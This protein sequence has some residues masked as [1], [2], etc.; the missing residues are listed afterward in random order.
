MRRTSSIYAAMCLLGLPGLSP[1]ATIV[2]DA[3]GGGDFTNIQAALD[4]AAD[5]DRVLVRPGTYS[6][7][8]PL[9]F[10]RLLP[11]FPLPPGTRDLVLESEAGPS[12]T[13]I[14]GTNQGAVILF[15]HAESA[16]SAVIGFTLTGGSYGVAYEGAP[17]G[18]GVGLSAALRD[19]IIEGNQS[20]G[21]VWSDG[22]NPAV[23]EDCVIVDNAGTGAG[24]PEDRPDGLLKRCLIARN[25]RFGVSYTTAVDCEIADNGGAGIVGTE[26]LG[27]RITGNALGVECT[28]TSGSEVTDCLIARNTG[29]GVHGVESSC[30]I[31][32]SAI[33]ENG[34][35]GVSLSG[36]GHLEVT[37]STIV[38]NGGDGIFICDLNNER[39]VVESSI[40]WG[41]AGASILMPIDCHE[42]D[43]LGQ[44]PIVRYC[45]TSEPIP[46]E[47]NISADPLFCEGP[48][49]D[50]LAL[51][52]GS[53]CIGTGFDGA[54]MGASA[55]T[56][57][58]SIVDDGGPGTQAEGNWYV[59]GSPSPYGTQSL[60][61]RDSGAVYHFR[62]IV[63]AAMEYDVY[64]WWT[65][66]S[67]R[68]EDV[69]VE[70]DHA[71]GTALVRI[72]Q[73][74]N[75]GRWNKIGR[76]TLDGIARV[77]IL[78][79]G[80]G[81]TSA[82]AVRIVPANV[83]GSPVIL[84][85]G[86]PGTSSAG[87]WP[88]SGGPMPYGA[89]S[90]YSKQ[91]GAV[92][93]YA[94][95]LPAPGTYRVSLWW[96]AISSRPD[97]VRVD[98]RHVAGTRTVYVNQRLNGGRWNDAGVY[99][100]GDSA[101]VTIFSAGNGSTCAD[102]VRLEPASMPLFEKI[103]DNGQEGSR[104][105]GGWSISGGDDPYGANSLYSKQAGATYTYT[106]TAPEPGNYEV[107]LWWTE[108]P[109]RL[110]TVPVDIVT[111]GK[112]TTRFVDQT[113]SGGAWNSLGSF[114]AS[115]A[116]TVRIRSPGGGTTCAD[117]ARI[118]AQ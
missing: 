35:D 44:F 84:D 63:P 2:V 28:E 59:S 99:A 19:C 116:L 90:L 93:R 103:I 64:L 16:A 89:N 51:S 4:A 40:I 71:D 113:R 47:G 88:I 82:D 32:N 56:C 60:Y 96:T 39:S 52:P 66:W 100:F 11:P 106:F 54:D 10:N 98:I 36:F 95:S 81:S 33:L 69:P 37:G 14:R 111:E 50:T 108:W 8:E 5:G 62:L 68:L 3:A 15:Q 34:D 24:Q 78:S 61:S 9:D 30:F 87:Y 70:V 31:T 53:P 48:V 13:I 105:T 104:S 115:D 41:N 79:L 6:I 101:L 27:S 77:R 73:R 55:G 20:G 12:E 45:D 117:A 23:I 94:P 91:A 109:S 102:A 46:G 118:R 74:E 110:S 7:V 65:E 83:A 114:A 29:H 1:G 49:G 75:G 72:D 21:V 57:S 92:Y 112:T 18:D 80:P 38:R 43:T 26:A 17:Y 25:G 107:F 42:G 58:G 86:E 85:N 97:R 76:W 22:R 67:S